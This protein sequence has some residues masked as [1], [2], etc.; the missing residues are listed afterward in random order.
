LEDY[1]YEIQVSWKEAVYFRERE[2][3]KQKVQ[4]LPKDLRWCPTVEIIGTNGVYVVID[5]NIAGAW[6]V[7]YL[8]KS[9]RV[10][11]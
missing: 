11:E 6:H 9:D 4:L 1:V 7:P 3:K 8:D 2:L 5:P 10:R